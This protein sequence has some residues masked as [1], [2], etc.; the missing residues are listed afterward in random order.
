MGGLTDLEMLY[1]WISDGCRRTEKEPSGWG[2]GPTIQQET[3]GG[4]IQ[5][6][7]A[8]IWT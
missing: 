4:R 8:T 1:Y 3:Q 2:C 6:L 7:N 5:D